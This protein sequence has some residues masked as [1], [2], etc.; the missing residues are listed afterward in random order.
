MAL[1]VACGF[2]VVG[3]SGGW[4]NWTASGATVLLLERR[5]KEV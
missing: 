2:R 3:T 1:H 4:R 5:S